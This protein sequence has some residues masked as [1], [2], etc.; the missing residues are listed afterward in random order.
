MLT[1]LKKRRSICVNQVSGFLSL[2]N[3]NGMKGHN[4]INTP[5]HPL[6]KFEIMV[7]FRIIPIYVTYGRL[8]PS[9]NSVEGNA[10]L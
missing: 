7:M 2:A 8:E 10:H 5:S 4:D 1:V 9:I 3:F 6:P